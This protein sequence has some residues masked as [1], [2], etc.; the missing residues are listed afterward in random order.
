PRLEIRS[1]SDDL[2]PAMVPHLSKYRKLMP[3][4]ALLFE[5]ADRAAA[6]GEQPAAVEL[7]RAWQAAAFCSYLESHAARMY[8]CITTPEV[9]AARELAEKFKRGKLPVTF[10]LR[11]VYL[12]GWSGLGTP[13]EVRAALD[14]LGDAN[15]VR[16][17]NSER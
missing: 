2:H 7:E 16:E 1:R 10:S 4:A 6:G 17:V 5:L 12:K 14:I 13:N 8:S 11:D 9:R 3:A 15:W